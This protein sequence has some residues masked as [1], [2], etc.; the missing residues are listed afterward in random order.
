MIIVPDRRQ[1]RGNRISTITV[2]PITSGKQQKQ[3]DHTCPPN[4]LIQISRSAAI[5]EPEGLCPCCGPILRRTRKQYSA[6]EKIRIVLS[7]LRGEDSI[8][9]RCRRP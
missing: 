1:T 3:W 4:A 8:A 7:G 5:T 6:E 9:K 2:R